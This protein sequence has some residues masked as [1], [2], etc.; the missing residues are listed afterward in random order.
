MLTPVA[1]EPVWPEASECGTFPA[2]V[3]RY[4]IYGGMSDC[5]LSRIGEKPLW[6]DL[7][8]DHVQTLRFTFVHGHALFFR[9]VRIDTLP[10]G[11]G[12]MVV[13]GTNRRASIRQESKRIGPHTVQ[14]SGEEMAQID[15][16]VAQP[17]TFEHEIGTWDKTDG[18]T[19]YMHCQTLDLERADA[20]GYRTSSVNIGCN[21]PNKLMPLIEEI[22][23]LAGLGQVGEGARY[24][25]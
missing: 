23:R 20:D 5:Y 7:A 25:Y 10:D 14:L 18:D 3:R 8:E 21:H 11:S 13:D 6:R 15:R 4:T 24:Y 22:V 17:G 12:R 19:L 2:S 9:S 16:L 1:A